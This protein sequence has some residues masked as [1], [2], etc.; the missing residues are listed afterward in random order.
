MAIITDIG[1]WNDIHP[2]NKKDVGYRL[3]L[4]ARKIAYK[5]K[6]LTASGPIATKAA[7]KRDQVS[8]TFD[9]AGRGLTTRDGNT[10]QYFALS[11]DGKTFVWA[12]AEITGKNTVRVWNNR[13]KHPVAVRYAWAN[14]PATANL[15]SED[16]LPASPFEFR[17]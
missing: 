4:L 13:V 9:A 10:P 7:F 8:V 11:E 5:E 17:K 12:K 2:L 1:E 15:Y 14:N 3:A 16:G 6:G